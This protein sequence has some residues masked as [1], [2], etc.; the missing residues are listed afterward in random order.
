MN[1]VLLALLAPAVYTLNNYIDKYLVSSK[2]KDYRAIFI[3]SAIV[4]LGAGTLIWLF[5]GRPILSTFDAS[6]VLFT[7][8]LTVWGLP[9]YF[10]AL[11]EEETTTIII[12]FQTI[13]V[14]S[15]ILAFFILGETITLKQLLGF[16][17]ILICA[18]LVTIKKTKGKI[19]QI[20]PA[21]FYV[22]IFNTMWALAGVLIKFA[23]NANSFTK[24][25]PYESWGIGIGGIALFFL[26][27]GIRKAFIKSVK[28]LKKPTIGVL[29]GNELVF[30]SA[31]AIT[32][33]AYALGPVALVSVLGGTQVFFG[34]IY[35]IVLT[36]IFPKIFD[37]DLSRN[38][39]IKKGILGLGVLIGIILIG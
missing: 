18:T 27:P 4:G 30:V 19:F 21:F 36:L 34:I 6:I 28:T 7:G 9:L 33:L 39:L 38:T 2:I 11:S 35:G 32:F 29:L 8:I 12:L 25:L 16:A 24:I 26:F 22:L 1:W 20:S 17:I 37:E 3:Y 5:T 10:K 23:I 15:F 14:I 31:K 13:P